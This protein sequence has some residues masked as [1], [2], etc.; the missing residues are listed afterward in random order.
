MLAVPSNTDFCKIPTLYDIP[1]LFKLH[2]KSFGMDPSAPM[3]ID[4]VNVSL[5]HIL[6]NFLIVVQSSYPVFRFFS[7][8][9][10]YR[11]DTQ[12]QLSNIFLSGTI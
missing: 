5:F 7:E 11:R 9:G 3:I 10:Y 8:S 1:N 4:S 2:S 6:A 12:H